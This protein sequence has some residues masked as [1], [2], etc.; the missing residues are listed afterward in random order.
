MEQKGFTLIELLIVVAIIGFIAAIAIPNL[1]VAIQKGKQKATMADLKSLGTA[2]ESY[3]TDWTMA[4]AANPTVSGGT[5]WFEP[6][7]I[8]I[9]PRAD[10]W[11]HPFGYLFAA[12]LDEYSI[13]SAGRD[14]TSAVPA[15]VTIPAAGPL[16]ICTRLIDFNFDVCFSD[17]YFTVGPDTKR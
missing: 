14:G 9:C 7:Y 11:G 12:S 8:K 4:P 17:G 16:Y 1:M 2:I 6:Y 3:V 5:T 13:F 10:G 15:A